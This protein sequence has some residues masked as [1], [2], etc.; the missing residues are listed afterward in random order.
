M[1]L[2]LA[3]NFS[4]FFFIPLFLQEILHY[5]PL[6]AGTAFL[7]LGTVMFVVSR[8]TPKL[9]ARFGAQPLIL[10]GLALAAGGVVWLTRI[11]ATTQYM[12]VIFVST[13]LVGAGIGTFLMPLTG[14]ILQQVQPEDTGVASGIL[15]TTQQVGGALGLA[16]QLTVYEATLRDAGLRNSGL[17]AVI[18][19]GMANAF[20]VGATFIACTIAVVLLMRTPPIPERPPELPEA[21]A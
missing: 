18:A 17:P 6:E 12:P 16:I 10:T 14:A 5:S 15:Q 8:Y 13:I 2:T 19:H 3:C 11:S 20:I 21:R 9:L 4:V 7:P 1:L